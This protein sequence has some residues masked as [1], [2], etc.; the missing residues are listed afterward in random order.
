MVKDE[1]TNHRISTCYID[2]ELGD[3]SA[4]GQGRLHH[5]QSK[6]SNDTRRNVSSSDLVYLWPH[7]QHTDGRLGVV[8]WGHTEFSQKTVTP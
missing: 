7:I 5:I 6:Y 1:E 8:P 3:D 2:F 4:S